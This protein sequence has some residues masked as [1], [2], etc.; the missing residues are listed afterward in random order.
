MTK[1]KTTF[2][3][4]KQEVHAALSMHDL[5]TRLIAERMSVYRV[6]EQQYSDPLYYNR[7]SDTRY[8]DPQKKIGTCY[9]SFSDRVALA[10]TLQYGK[11]GVGSPVLQSEIEERSLHHLQTTRQLV[12]V[13]AAALARN[14]GK[15]LG[16]IVKSRGQGDEGYAYTQTLSG[17]VMRWQPAVDGILYPSQVYPITASLEGCNLVL[18]DGRPTQ[19]V[20]VSKQPLGSVVLSNGETVGELLNRMR[21]PIE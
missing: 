6:Q 3:V 11:S 19:L 17:V 7:N 14:A 18:F 9:V 8:G 10:E 1:K 5:P 15:T 4:A 12:V 16:A 21:V 2:E 13:D 20:A